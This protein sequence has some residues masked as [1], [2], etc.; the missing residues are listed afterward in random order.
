M[1]P[2]CQ[3]YP[4]CNRKNKNKEHLREAQVWMGGSCWS[5]NAFKTSKQMSKG[6]YIDLDCKAKVWAINVKVPEVY[7]ISE[8]VG[9]NKVNS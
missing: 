8:A 3:K 4:G 5:L 7:I 9:I 1:I 2:K 6:R